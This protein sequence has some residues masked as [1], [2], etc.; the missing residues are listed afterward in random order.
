HDLSSIGESDPFSLAARGRGIEPSVRTVVF[1][2][3]TVT[4]F[5]DRVA[6]PSKEPHVLSVPLNILDLVSIR[7]GSTARDSTAQSMASPTLADELCSPSLWF[8]DHHNTLVLAASATACLISQ[9]ASVT[10]RIRVGSGGVMLPNHA[11]L[12]VAEHYGTLANIHGD[13][14]DLGLGRAP[15]TDGMTAQALDR[16]S[17]RLNSSHASLS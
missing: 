10:E 11:P 1:R 14:I 2:V 9:A 4:A 17:T 8:A 15:G 7:E 6:H 12:M 3:C 5:C 13:R 16:K